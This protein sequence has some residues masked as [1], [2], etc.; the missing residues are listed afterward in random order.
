MRAEVLV[1]QVQISHEITPGCAIPCDCVGRLSDAS[2][3]QI[4]NMFCDNVIRFELVPPCCAEV[5]SPIHFGGLLV[6]VGK[7]QKLPLQ[8]AAQ[9][10]AERRTG[11]VRCWMGAG[12][13]V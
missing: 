3:Y 1:S 12:A 9:I 8:R 2:H 4:S 5:S 10:N 11:V 7:C 6:D 13:S